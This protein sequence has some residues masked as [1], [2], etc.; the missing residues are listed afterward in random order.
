M[1]RIICACTAAVLA[2]GALSG[3]AATTDAEALSPPSA[4]AE[5]DPGATADAIPT[6]SI[7]FVNVPTA[8]RGVEADVYSA[9]AVYERQLWRATTEGELGLSLYDSE[10]VADGEATVTVVGNLRLGIRDIVVDEV[11]ATGLVCRDF[12]ELTIE[13]PDSRVPAADAA[14]T[15]PAPP[16]SACA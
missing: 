12:S 3:C 15:P 11:T 6:T 16:C 10:A 13:G 8:M 7:E 2:V 5:A 4:S 1:V 9:I 14:T